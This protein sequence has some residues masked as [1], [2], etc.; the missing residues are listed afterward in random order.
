M[1]EYIRGR[2]EELT[3]DTAIIEAGGI[4]YEVLITLPDYNKLQLTQNKEVRIY[5]HEAIREDAHILYGFLNAEARA[6]FRLLTGV[7]GVGPGTAR[8]ILSAMPLETLQQS[9]ADSDITPLKA[10]KGI[11]AKTAQRI[12]VDLH[13][14]INSIATTL[15]T[16]TGVS[17]PSFEEALAALTT[18]GFAH[19]ASVKALR[20]LYAEQPGLTV[21]EAV[22]QALKMM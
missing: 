10:V 18:L 2:A 1:I 7:S 19:N 20:K 13:D 12:I 3:P 8:T 9:I 6:L 4:G 22:R 14:K 5:I 21:E 17:A 15:I 11:G 16:N